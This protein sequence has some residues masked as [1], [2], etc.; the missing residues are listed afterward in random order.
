M[1]FSPTPDHHHIHIADSIH[2][3]ARVRIVAPIQAGN[4]F[5][6]R[7]ATESVGPAAKSADVGAQQ[8]CQLTGK[9][10][11]E[12]YTIHSSSLHTQTHIRIRNLVPANVQRARIFGGNLG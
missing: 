11:S 5:Q 12:Y 10:P 4:V 3:R 9:Q 6:I 7:I 8:S 2:A 1:R